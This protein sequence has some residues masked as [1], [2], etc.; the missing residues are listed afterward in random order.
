MGVNNEHLSNRHNNSAQRRHHQSRYSPHH[1][2]TCHRATAQSGIRRNQETAARN[3]VGMMTIPHSVRWATTYIVKQKTIKWT[4]WHWTKDA[5]FTSCGHPIVIG[6]CD[7]CPLFPETNDDPD[8]V[9]CFYCKKAL[10]EQ[11]GNDDINP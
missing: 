3:K 2:Q 7:D 4:K 6:A 11:G 8:V 5:K 1:L 10:K 9:D